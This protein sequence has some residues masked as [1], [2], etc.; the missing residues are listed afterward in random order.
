MRRA[1][2][3]VGDRVLIVTA[4]AQLDATRGAIPGVELIGEPVARNTAAA[5]GLAAATLGLR[6]PEAV[7]AILPA[8]QHVADEAGLARV[9]EVGFAA[10]E[11]DDV[12]GTV[13]ITPTR[14]ET[15]FGYLEVATATPG[16]VTPVLRFVE[17][18]DRATAERYLAA[19]T[20]LWNAGMFVASA[21]RLLAELDAHAAPIGR[22][23]RDIAARTSLASDVYPT[24]T[25]I[26]IDHA[27][28]EHATRIV[29]IPAS[30]GW[31]DVGS[32]AALA[33]LIDPDANHNA[34]VG[35][36]LALD[37]TG[38]VMYCDDDTLIVTLGVSDLIVVKSGNAILVLP[39]HAAQ[40][41]RKVVDA[42]SARADRERF[43]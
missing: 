14:A 19:G 11:A 31:D 20:Y 18:P 41:V 9:L 30:I 8:D 17:K 36:S 38:N 34:V 5:I 15:G 7:L 29:T 37:A 26:S 39:K 16:V 4:E 33:A 10:V 23:V 42:V 13:G 27:V 32:W 1:Q 6:D 2:A 3:V 25:S 43:L 12:I 40:D 35:D 22:G 21:R 24:L 28:M